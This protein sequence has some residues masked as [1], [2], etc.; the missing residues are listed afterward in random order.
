MSIGKV[1]VFNNGG[2]LVQGNGVYEVN[3][4]VVYVYPNGKG[5]SV[6]VTATAEDEYGN[7]KTETLEKALIKCKK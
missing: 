6:K 1:E 7:S 4:D 2:K 3:G 5:W